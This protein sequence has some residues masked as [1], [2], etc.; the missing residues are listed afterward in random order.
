VGGCFIGKIACNAE[1]PYFPAMLAEAMNV[2][3]DVQWNP[4]RAALMLDVT[5]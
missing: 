2:L 4:T 1:H 3:A 5:A